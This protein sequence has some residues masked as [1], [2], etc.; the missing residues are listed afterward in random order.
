MFGFNSYWILAKC[1]VFETEPDA[2]V[3]N[4]FGLILN[5]NAVSQQNLV[6]GDIAVRR[7]RS[8]MFCATDACYWP[9][10][11][12]GIVQIPYII[13]SDFAQKD[14]DKIQK[15]MTEF[16]TLTCIDFVERKEENDY[17]NIISGDGCWSFHG[18]TGGAQTLSLKKPWCLW[19]GV[20]EHELEHSLGLIHEHTRSDRDNYVKIMWQYISPRARRNFE[21]K[22]KS[23]N[24]GL[25]Y[26]YA[27]I[28]HYGRKQFSNTSGEAT[29]IPIPDESVLIGHSTGLSNLD[30]AKIN[31]LYNCSHCS[32]V[33]HTSKG[34]LTSANYPSKYQSDTN[35][36]WLI[37]L[38]GNPFR[39]L[40]S[41]TFDVFDLQSSEGCTADYVKVYDGISKSDKVL[42]DKTCGIKIPPTL[43]SSKN[44]MLIEF[45][46]DHSV[47]GTGFRA[48]YT[49]KSAFVYPRGWQ[50]TN[51]IN[52]GVSD[53]I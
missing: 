39:K 1:I 42:L 6:E 18:R 12:D 50:L 41:L 21:K 9:Q 7:S 47:E 43:T 24:L 29:I 17:L 10:S 5:A 11:S 35:C 23:N 46:S 44:T 3:D 28:M 33:L 19:M 52:S 20:I 49:S 31:R 14:R 37:R 32:T 4:V 13:S 38:P 22:T 8:A 26:D 30:V 40:V 48:S 36:L 53:F 2:E 51:G 45:V 25:E 15:S 16:E 27:S 34:L